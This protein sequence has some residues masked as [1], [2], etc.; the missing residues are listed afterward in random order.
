MRVMVNV[1]EPDL[2]HCCM[3]THCRCG[4]AGTEHTLQYT[5]GAGHATTPNRV[6]VMR[7]HQTTQWTHR[8]TPPWGDTGQKCNT[9]CT[10]YQHTS[11]TGG[12]P[13]LPSV[14]HSVSQR[15]TRERKQRFGT[16]HCP[17]LLLACECA[18]RHRTIHC[19]HR[20]TQW[21]H[22]Q[23]TQGTPHCTHHYNT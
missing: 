1:W 15:T 12:T 8:M 6:Q 18:H 21:T 20:P 3:Q 2:K 7:Q 9:H 16:A 14:P 19:T 17:T 4:S 23:Q 22:C 5:Q 11:N 10:N 13:L